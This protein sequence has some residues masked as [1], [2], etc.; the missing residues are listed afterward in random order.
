MAFEGTVHGS[1]FRLPGRND[2]TSP[3]HRNNF[4][5]RRLFVACT[6]FIS[7][8]WCSPPQPGEVPPMQESL[9][10]AVEGDTEVLFFRSWLALDGFLG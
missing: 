7:A 4:L 2:G 1:G 8:R 6:L 9:T 3:S 5:I 10:T